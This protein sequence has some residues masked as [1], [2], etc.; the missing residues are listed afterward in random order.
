M[1]L[2]QDFDRWRTV[3]LGVLH[4]RV[5]LPDNQLVTYLQRLAVVDTFEFPK[6]H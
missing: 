4:L 2:V 3:G 5:V 1:K 6:Q